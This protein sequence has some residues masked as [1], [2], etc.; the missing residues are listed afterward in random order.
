MQVYNDPGA[1]PEKPPI[2]RKGYPTVVLAL[3]GLIVAVSL[4]Q[5]NAPIQLYQWIMASSVLVVPASEFG[6]VQP[7]GPY[8][9]YLLHTLVHGNLFHLVMNMAALISFGPVAALALGRG[10]RGAVLFLAFF[11]FCAI[12]GGVATYIWSTVWNDPTAMIGASS[13]ISGLLPAVGYMRGGW[14]GAWSI[15]VP[16]LVINIGLGLLGGDIG[17]MQIAW[18]AHLGGLAAGFAFPVFLGLARTRS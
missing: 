2:F 18:T 15:S 17:I 16:W 8:A 11:A 7:F 14:Q 9:P 3:T 10:Q 6:F 12:G 4:I 1:T 5:F 13:A